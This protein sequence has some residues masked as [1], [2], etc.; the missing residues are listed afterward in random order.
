MKVINLFAAPGSGKSTT[1][2][3]LFFKMK[4]ARKSVE[5]VTEY[6]K[7]LTYEGLIGLVDQYRIF[8]EQERR[9]RRLIDHV[10][11]AITDSPLPLSLIYASPER[12]DEMRDVVLNR[13]DTYDN[14]NFFIRRTKPYWKV[15]RN[16]TEEESDILAT[17]IR[18]MLDDHDIGYVEVDGDETAPDVIYSNVFGKE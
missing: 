4:I 8:A 18:G 9:Q 1:G 5:L 15:G 2:A 12:L 10:E 11:W 17:R 14:Y 6:A 3:G 7:D 13:F 16:Q